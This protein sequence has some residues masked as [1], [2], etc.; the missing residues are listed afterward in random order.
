MPS[1]SSIEA[2]GINR[3]EGEDVPSIYTTPLV[4]TGR[5][6]KKGKIVNYFIC[7]DYV[8][9]YLGSGHSFLID[10]DNLHEIL[11]FSWSIENKY[12]YR[13]QTING[14]S[15]CKIRIYRQIMRA[16]AGQIVD[17]ING[18]TFDNRKSNL[19]FCTVQENLKNRKKREA[20]KSSSRFKGVSKKG[21]KWTVSITH[22]YK[23]IHLGVFDTEEQAAIAYNEAS[24]H[25]H[26][27]YGR[28][29]EVKEHDVQYKNASAICDV[30]KTSHQ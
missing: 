2:D 18:D 30:A 3:R 15:N 7:N 19:R 11:P 6:P 8:K 16:E 14:K 4:A 5:K 23:R 13:V 24:E 28:K 10:L 1:S 27:A 25:L 29:N 12:V 22:N 26:G 20:H 21:K 17:H 9:I